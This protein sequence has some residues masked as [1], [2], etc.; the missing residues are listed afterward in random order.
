M[1]KPKF[2]VIIPTYNRAQS[3]VKAIDSVLKQTFS[4][5]EVIVVDDGSTDNTEGVIASINDQRLHYIKKKNEERSIAR[6]FGVEQAKGEYINFLDSDDYQLSNHLEVAFSVIRNSRRPDIIHLGYQLEDQWGNVLLER[7]NL[8]EENL[9]HRMLHENILHGNAMF[10][11]R[12]I[13]LEH[14]FIHSPF[15]FLSEDWYLW[16]KLLV[17]YKI[18]FDNIITSVVVEHEQRSLKTI[19]AGKLIS[20]TNLIVGHLKEDKPFFDKL[21]YG[22]KVFLANQYTFLTLILALAKEKKAT[23]RYLLK[24]LHQDITV[25]TRKRFLASVKHL[26]KSYI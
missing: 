14:R 22:A 1:S 8:K 23:W 12:T 13:L 17:R 6:N 19:D 9:S 2:S 7:V 10:I 5:F 16:M 3:L 15:A 11:K 21:G 20:C 4:D 26:M 18:Q 25:I 24:A